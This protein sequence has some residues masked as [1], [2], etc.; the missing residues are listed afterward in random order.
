M[1]FWQFGEDRVFEWRME[2]AEKKM[3]GDVLGARMLFDQ[4]KTSHCK[5]RV[6]RFFNQVISTIT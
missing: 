1:C 5:R 4:L 2:M 6:E 3:D